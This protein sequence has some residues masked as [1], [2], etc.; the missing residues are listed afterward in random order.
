MFFLDSWGIKITSSVH[1]ILTNWKLM[2]NLFY[3]FLAEPYLEAIPTIHILLAIH[4]RNKEVFNVNELNY[5]GISK[6]D[7]FWMTLFLS[8]FSGSLGMAKFLKLGPCQIVPS[9]KW[10]CGFFLVF[11]SIAPTLVGKGLV[12][13]FSLLNNE[14]FYVTICLIWIGTWILPQFLLVRP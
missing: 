12:L 6:M 11:I 4:M 3:I 1:Y 8:V 5:L 7:M 13:A 2:I 14:S 10:H 9:D